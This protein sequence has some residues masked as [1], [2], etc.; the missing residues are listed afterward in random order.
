MF[1]PRRTD[2]GER[3]R[4]GEHGEAQD[5]PAKSWSEVASRAEPAPGPRRSRGR[6][7]LR[8]DGLL[9]GHQFDGIE[10]MWD[11]WRLRGGSAVRLFSE[12]LAKGLYFFR[13][14]GEEL[15]R[16]P[17]NRLGSHNHGSG[18]Y[19]LAMFGEQSC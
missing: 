5:A 13:S 9:R 14:G 10:I 16:I 17:G 6:G 15:T 12:R 2:Y 8:K 11:G 4:G 7:G 1:V 3:E 18:F 19:A